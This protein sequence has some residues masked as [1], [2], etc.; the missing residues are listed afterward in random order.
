[1]VAR[2]NYDQRV[3]F[4]GDFSAAFNSMIEQLDARS[5]ELMDNM[6][7]LKKQS[8]SLSQMNVLLTSITAATSQMI[9][10][11]SLEKHEVLYHNFAARDMVYDA[12]VEALFKNL[13]DANM[14]EGMNELPWEIGDQTFYYVVQYYP[15]E[16]MDQ[17]SIA[18]L[19]TDISAD[20]YRLQ[21]L[22]NVAYRDELT[23]LFNRFHGMNR[24]TEIRES[25]NPFT[26]C[27]I[28]LDNLKYINDQFGHKE[29]DF[30]IVTASR[31]LK[32]L[33]AIVARIGGDEFMAILPGIT[34]EESEEKC[35]LL[36]DQLLKIVLDAEKP[37]TCSMS[38]GSVYCGANETMSVS[39]ILSVA[40]ER[41]YT[42]KKSRKKARAIE[43]APH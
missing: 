39:E 11:A 9:I 13:P 38:Y 4:M 40:D 41:M 21:Q 34:K 36:N 16:W 6:E 18:F 30:Y 3:D 14:A 24:L 26:L 27:F 19:M 5:K 17:N 31:L 15:L 8:Q 28:D 29:G 1:V 35:S 22:E 43:T 32:S 33:S 12:F 7:K 23:G 42:F 20:K 2:G 37:Y 25:R 10:V